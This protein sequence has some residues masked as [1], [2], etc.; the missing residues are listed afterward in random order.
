MYVYNDED[1]APM[2]DPFEGYHNPTGY[3]SRSEME[4]FEK[5]KYI[6]DEEKKHGP[7]NGCWN[8]Q[9]YDWNKEACTKNWNN[10]DESHYIPERDD[11]KPD[12][13]CEDYERDP[14]VTWEDFFGGDE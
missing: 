9:L 4:Y 7:D 11:R 14:D 10:L 6:E 3:N 2:N 5:R 12:D 13:Q 1:N 8:C